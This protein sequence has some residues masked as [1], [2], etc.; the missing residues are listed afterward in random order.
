MGISVEANIREDHLMADEDSALQ[1]ILRELRF[2]GVNDKPLEDEIAKL[3]QAEQVPPDIDEIGVRLRDTKAF[4]DRFP[5]NK[6]L[7]DSG[8]QQYTVRQYLTLEAD[9]KR[10]L[11]GRGMPPGFY[12]QPSD[13]QAWIAGGTS[14]DE[15]GAR[16]D[17]GYQAVRNAPANVVAEFQRLYGVSEGDLAAYFIDPTRARPTF[18]R[19]EAERQARSAAISAQAQQ[20]A[21]IQLQ[22]QEA[23]ALARAG[24]TPEQAQT[25]FT[26]I[27]ES[28]GLFAGQMQ[29]EEA[30]S[31]EEQIG[32][33][34][35]T[36]A[37]ARKAIAERRRRRTA[38]FEAGGG[39]AG[40]TQGTATGLTT[41]GQ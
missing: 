31:R 29:G 1:I 25:K 13:F 14:P 7:A 5:A 16:I 6:I 20:Q 32:A 37:A 10:T 24:V 2:L 38:Q 9:F 18:D 21:Q 28:Q 41:I 11:Q 33:T 27:A 36:N 19:Y 35:G 23:E 34:F 3:W 30:V 39:F 12:D 4:Q 8:E 26:D 15:V 17:Q 22:T 40:Q